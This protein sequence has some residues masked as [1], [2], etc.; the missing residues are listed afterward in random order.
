MTNDEQ[1]FRS[2]FSR[3]GFLTAMGAAGAGLAVSPAFG[4][5][6]AQA[7]PENKAVRAA[8]DP[9]TT[10]RVG[11]LHLQ[12]GA[13]AS[14]E[15]VASWHSLQPVRKP[16]VLLGRPDGGYERSVAADTISYTDAK[17]GQVVYAHHARLQ[18]LDADQDYAYAAVHEGAE[19]EFGSFHT[20]PRGRSPFTFTSFGDQGTP[21]TGKRYT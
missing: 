19:A 8:G 9:L 20:G 5:G 2:G 1:V 16:R 7:S 10:P 15:V 14:S 4:S 18:R 3:R 17:S 12:F 11:G 21:T 6:V 13:D